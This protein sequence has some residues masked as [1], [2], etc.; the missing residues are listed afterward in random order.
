LVLLAQGRGEDALADALREPE[1]WCR[2]SALAIVHHAADRRDES[3]VALQEL[4]ANHSVDAA[5]QIATVYAARDETDLA[6]AWLERAYAQHDTGLS[7]MKSDPL[8]RSL[9]VHPRWE[10]FL[11]KMAFPKSGE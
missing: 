1:E 8:L 10:G 4:I 11:G 6:F 9:H 2:L 3:E 7:D 5:Y